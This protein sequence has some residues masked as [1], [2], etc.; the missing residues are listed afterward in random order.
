MKF[1]APLA[2]LLSALPMFAQGGT[3]ADIKNLP[4]ETLV[5]TVDGRKVTA[6]ELQSILRGL[7]PAQQQQVF[8]NTRQFLEQYGLL[9]RLSGMAEKA[10][11]DKQSPLKEQLEYNRMVGLAQAQLMKTSN[12]ITVASDEV[13]K[14]YEANKDDYEQARVKAIYIP[15][16]PR[17]AE[18]D[19][20]D[21]KVMSEEDA[22]AK[23]TKV[24]AEIRKGAD[25]VKMVKEH[26]GDPTSAA[27]D[28][29]FGTIR[30]SDKLPD[31]IKNVI[32]SLKPGEVSE[33]VRQPNGYYLFRLEEVTVQ[34][35]NEV[36]AKIS[37]ELKQAKLNEWVKAT[38]GSV[39]IT[40]DNEAF[41]A[42]PAAAA[43]PAP[44][45]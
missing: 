35:L 21:K 6:V 45:K 2:L 37:E 4:P 17:A 43:T 44:A 30:R 34:P 3:P 8:R 23:V 13:R 16:S 1:I 41:F 12:E 28:G 11:L 20:G 26:S 25:F 10:G 9:R 33:P 5:A 40:I 18:Q 27:S 42:S 15:F 7:S 39:E 38:Q 29:D 24:L 36:Q 19:P 22:K 32:F 31:P 14:H